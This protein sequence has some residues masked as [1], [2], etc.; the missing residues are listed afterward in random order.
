MQ[1]STF[2]AR[3]PPAGMLR[4]RIAIYAIT[5]V[6]HALFGAGLSYGLGR[7]GT[8]QPAWVAVAVAACLVAALP[9]RLR[10]A[11]PDRPIGGARLVLLEEPYYAHWCAAV[12]ACP[13]AMVGAP[14]AVALGAPLGAALLGSYGLALLLTMY[15]VLV[16]RRWVR[17]RTIDV[18]IPGLDAA[19]DD[20]RIA[21]LSDLHIGGL[22]PR[23]RTRRWI[24]LT[25]ALDADLVALTGDY[26]TNG[27][28]F[29]GDI[30]AVLA[31]L[32]GRD[33]T[34]AIMG[35]HDYFG[36]G[37]PLVALLRARGISVLRNEHVV[38]SRGAQRLTIAG[39]DDT[40]TRRADVD[41]ALAGRDAGAPLIALAHDP[42][43]FP[44][45]ARRG[46]ALVLSGH[47]HWGQI[48]VPFAATRYNLSTLSYRYSAGL[49]RDGPATLYVSPGLGTTGPPLRLGAPPEITLFRLHPADTAVRGYR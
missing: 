8:P 11:R 28:A 42:R 39:V 48:A 12:L 10:Q 25:N 27:T 40:W 5:L 13:L 23:T 2:L 36:D 4:V 21:H 9:G 16:R 17:V 19:F 33:G 38:L 32:R 6:T 47:T 30:A 26:V 31:E 20:Y 15:G 34:L 49:Y 18:A 37:E 45:L 3:R 41:R 7:I 35:N 24:H 22:W 1:R 44:A 14:P 46:A 29:H 43:L